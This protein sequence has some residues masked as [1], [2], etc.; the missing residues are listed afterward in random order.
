MNL[1][2]LAHA[3]T[4]ALVASSAVL[5]AGCMAPPEDEE[6]QGAIES[7]VSSKGGACPVDARIS[8]RFHGGHDGVD[9]A[10]RI[11]TPIYAVAAGEVTAS[12][13]AQGYGQWIRIAHDDGS[14]TEYGHMSRRFVQVGDRVKAGERIALVGNEG[15]STG[16]H[17]HLRTY[18]SASRVG[19]GN[20]M[21]P[22]DYLAARGVS[23]PCT[24]GGEA[25]TAPEEAETEES[26]DGSFD[27]TVEPW[28]TANVREAPSLDAEVIGSAIEDRTYEASCWTRGDVVT[29]NGYSHDKWVKI[30]VGG[31]SGYVSG[32][33]LRGDETGDVTVQCD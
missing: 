20:G 19:S 16:P 32:I 27:G 22:E 23:L 3:W 1:L 7:R 13:P 10:N 25:S 6:E 24:P 28:T 4:V 33:F 17:L 26:N 30:A 5:A 14:M 9:L 12:G 11:G 18:R 2:R 21:D 8:Q 15:R 29:S 31:T